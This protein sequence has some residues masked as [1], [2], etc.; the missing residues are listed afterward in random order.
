MIAVRSPAPAAAAVP[1]AEP[2]ISAATSKA[3]V[4]RGRKLVIS[5]KVT[6]I[7][8]GTDHL[9]ITAPKLGRTSRSAAGTYRATV[10]T[11][12]VTEQTVTVSMLVPR[13][14]KLGHRQ[15]AVRI[16][17]RDGDETAH[18]TRTARFRIKP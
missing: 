13:T 2:V 9:T 18:A 5:F 8:A 15:V 4:R 10:R 6:R 16:V 14:A 1:L 17:W 3:S 12:G 7:P 11:I